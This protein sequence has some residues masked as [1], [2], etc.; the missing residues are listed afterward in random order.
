MIDLSEA[1][2]KIKVL[3]S[4]GAVSLS[5]NRVR[6]YLETSPIYFKIESY[7]DLIAGAQILKRFLLSSSREKVPRP[8]IRRKFT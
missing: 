3:A 2:T 4:F 6:R 1:R 5:R 8:P 7:V